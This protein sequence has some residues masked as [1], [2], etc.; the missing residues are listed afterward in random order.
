MDHAKYAVTEIL[1]DFEH[2]MDQASEGGW[3]EIVEVS[4]S[5]RYN[6]KEVD[7]FDVRFKDGTIVRISGVVLS[8]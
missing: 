7:Q 8:K 2:S 6:G 5:V 1:G 4:P 3:G